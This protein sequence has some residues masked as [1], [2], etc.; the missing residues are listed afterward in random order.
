[1]I[2]RIEDDSEDSQDKK[3]TVTIEIKKKPKSK[4]LL[5]LLNILLE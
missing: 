4:S 5:I 2:D 3:L 1:M